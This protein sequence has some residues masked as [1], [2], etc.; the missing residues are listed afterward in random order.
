MGLVNACN[1]WDY[2]AWDLTGR[3][4][5]GFSKNLKDKLT[6]KVWRER[7]KEK[8]GGVGTACV[9]SQSTWWVLEIEISLAFVVQLPSYVW[10]FMTPWT[11]A[12]LAPLSSTV[13]WSLLKLMSMEQWCCLT[14]SFSGIRVSLCLQSFPASESS[15]VSDLPVHIQDWFP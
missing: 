11:A 4:S 13:S 8:E 3:T 2:K 15:P 12:H 10:F 7:W 9:K 5:K 14:I 6:R 1:V